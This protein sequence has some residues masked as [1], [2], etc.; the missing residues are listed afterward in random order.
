MVQ[1]MTVE[2]VNDMD[3]MVVMVAQV[4]LQ[5]VTVMEVMGVLRYAYFIFIDSPLYIGE[6]ILA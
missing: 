1:I 3:V 6:L 2:M 5:L 4:I